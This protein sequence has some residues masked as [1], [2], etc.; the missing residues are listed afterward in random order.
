MDLESTG[1]PADAAA[2]NYIHAAKTG[3]FICGAVRC[4]AVYA[5]APEGDVARVSTYGE[6]VGLAFQIVDDLLDVLGSPE[7]LGKSVGKD[8]AQQKATYPALHGVEESQRIAARLVHE[9]CAALAPYGSRAERLRDIAHF[10]I[11][12]HS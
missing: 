10:L 9:A 11:A 7:E 4:G 2:L 12:R 1:H 6:Q 3:A 8:M 5:N